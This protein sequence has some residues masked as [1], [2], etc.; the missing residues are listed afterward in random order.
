MGWLLT[1]V[2]A[3]AAAVAVYYARETVKETQRLR[4]EDRLA[5]L[6]EL[7][8][9]L[10]ELLQNTGPSTPFWTIPR[11]RFAAL[12]AAVDD[13]L[14]TC[15]KL[16]TDPEFDEPGNVQKDRAETITLEA[17]GEIQQALELSAGRPPGARRRS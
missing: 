9:E 15:Y 7:V 10:G 17:L 14:P 16:A 6:A 5:R 2:S 11:K 12:L 4:R 3:V 1:L 13:P 8:A